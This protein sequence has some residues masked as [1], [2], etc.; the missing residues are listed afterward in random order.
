LDSAVVTLGF[1]LGAQ[2][3]GL[4]GVQASRG[5][6]AA[7]F[8]R[9]PGTAIGKTLLDAVVDALLCIG[10][11]QNALTVETHGQRAGAGTLVDP[12]ASV[13]AK[14]RAS[15]AATRRARTAGLAVTGHA[16]GATRTRRAFAP[17]PFGAAALRL[18]VGVGIAP[19]GI[20]DALAGALVDAAQELAV[21]IVHVFA[22]DALLQHKI[23]VAL[24][25]ALGARVHA[26][27]ILAGVIADFDRFPGAC[28]ALLDGAILALR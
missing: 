10:C 14:L 28:H 2:A 20:W 19:P 4:G 22:T 8:E 12:F 16:E 7:D 23:S 13:A 18:V 26:G 9:L 17:E 1:A 24:I 11:A 25:V 6:A 15:A 21:R 3:A 27:G 5:L